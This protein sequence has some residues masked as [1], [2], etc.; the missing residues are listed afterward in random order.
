MRGGP[1][2]KDTTRK[3]ESLYIKWESL[4]SKLESLNR[5]REMEEKKSLA[6]KQELLKQRNLL[7]S[8][9]GFLTF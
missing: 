3:L 7:H 1:Y 2:T 4:K 5:K 8:I 6:L 9:K